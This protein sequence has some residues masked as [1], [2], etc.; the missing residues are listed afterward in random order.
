MKKVLL[1]IAY[2]IVQLTWG[3]LMNIIGLFAT[4]FCLAFLKGKTHKNGYGLI[5]EVKGNWGGVSLGAFAL[6]GSYNQVDGP[7]Y[8]PYWYEHTRCH[9]FG[10]SI[11]NMIFGPLFPFV[12]AIP[13][14][15]RYWLFY[16]GKLHTE[17]DGVWF[18]RTATNWGT[19][20]VSWIEHKSK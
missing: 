6:C 4:L 14:A 18:E 7:C 1:G 13:S 20:W 17:Y 11:Q 19:A 8:D 16:F 5:T 10:H 12:V 9:E 2:W 15:I 3:I